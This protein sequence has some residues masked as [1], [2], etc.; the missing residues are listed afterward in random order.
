MK[1]VSD[2]L[3]RGTPRSF[4]PSV[5]Y[6]TLFSEMIQRVCGG[7]AGVFKRRKAGSGWERGLSGC[8]QQC[9]CPAGSQRGMKIVGHRPQRDG[10]GTAKPS[11]G[12]DLRVGYFHISGSRCLAAQLGDENCRSSPAA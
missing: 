10:R 7:K 12:D 8:G 4:V 5:Y 6:S 2:A 3:R 11:E 1:V 9:P